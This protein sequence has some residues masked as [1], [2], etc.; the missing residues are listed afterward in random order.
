MIND[1]DPKHALCIRTMMGGF[2]DV[3]ALSALGEQVRMRVTHQLFHSMA[4]VLVSQVYANVR[5]GMRKELRDED[6]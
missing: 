6:Y 1:D 4:G 5:D 2:D 3:S